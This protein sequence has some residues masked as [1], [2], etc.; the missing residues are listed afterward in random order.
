MLGV[1]GFS[2][3]L[4]TGHYPRGCQ[5]RA[6]YGEQV[7]ATL[8]GELTRT[9]GRGWSKRNLANMCLFAQC[10]PRVEMVQTLSAQMCGQ[11]PVLESRVCQALVH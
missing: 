8:A 1:W 9:Y 6:R 5:E 10:S 7:M 3:P 2:L 11:V 4:I